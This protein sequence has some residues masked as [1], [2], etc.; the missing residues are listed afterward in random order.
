MH[1]PFSDAQLFNLGSHN[2][3]VLGKISTMFL[4][5]FSMHFQVNNKVGGGSDINHTGV[6]KPVA[7]L[8]EF[9]KQPM[10]MC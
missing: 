3:S 10:V 7:I 4:F 6:A 8:S 1:A 2:N 9:M 5:S